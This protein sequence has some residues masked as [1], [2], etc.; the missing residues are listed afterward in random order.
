[1]GLLLPIW[2]PLCQKFDQNEK[3]G[4]GLKDL[5][6]E[7]FINYEFILGQFALILDHCIWKLIDQ[8]I[9]N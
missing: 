4:I 9:R 3:I 7:F 8:K 5:K 2:G 1:M 6:K